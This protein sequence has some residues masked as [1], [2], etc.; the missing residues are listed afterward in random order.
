MKKLFWIVLGITTL[1]LVV[2]FNL[3]ALA[4]TPKHYTDLGF[5][6]LKNVEIPEYQR[7]QLSNGMTVYLMPD[8][9]LPLVRGTAII[10]TGNRLEPNE[11]VGLADLTGV[12]M[13][14]GG[15]VQH[16]ADKLNQILENK[17]AV[18]ETSI[19]DTSG[20]A[21]FES[22]SEDL[23]TV[24]SLFAEVLRS[25]LLPDDKLQLAKQ[26]L[27]GNIARRNDNPGAIANREF[28]KVI[29]G[30]DSPYARTAEYATLN[31]IELQDLV[32]FYQHYFHPN[33]IILGIVGDFDS[34][35]IKQL[36]ED[37]FGDW[38]PTP[39]TNEAIPNAQQKHNK[40]VF[41]VNQPH[42]T[43]SNIRIGHL[44][45]M[46]NEPDYPTLTVL[47]GVL[48][49][50]GGRLF[51]EIRS[52]QGLAYSVYGQ[53]QA[54]FDYPGV[55]IGGG[56]TRSE[57]TVAFIQSLKQ[58]IERIRN[59]PI[60]QAELDYAKDSILNS[61]V[62]NFQRPQQTISRLMRYEYFN[63]P[64]DFIFTYQNQVKTTT[65][66]QIQT[67]AQ[68]YLQPDNLVTLV[69]GNEEAINPP[70]STLNQDIV[71]LDITIPTP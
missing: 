47:N 44:A 27:S 15:T 51:N 6:P 55:F 46:A 26:Q 3:P 7:Y 61:F 18:V 36:I 53:W 40:G 28:F 45:G 5:S 67:A 31:N 54:N 49:G 29:Y 4:L 20:N 68:K 57:T 71:A 34:T 9:T 10:R 52:R 48:N 19:G 25:P 13:R 32:N 16:P 33:N 41:L 69:V 24:F 58:Q 59:Q 38:Q 62:F 21:S 22:L 66:K 11:K 43:Q 39:S 30:E 50:F 63:Y 64:S 56:Q 65:I 42:L 2:I 23:P 8:N 12:V 70:L 1:M 35:N 37:K 14:S 17:A 60:N